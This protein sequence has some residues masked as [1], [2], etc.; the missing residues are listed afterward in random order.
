MVVSKCATG[1]KKNTECL[2]RTGGQ[3]LNPDILTTGKIQRHSVEKMSFLLAFKY[4]GQSNEAVS[5]TDVPA[6][7][8]SE[9]S[10]SM[11]L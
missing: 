6:S 8:E 2:L 7:S 1:K 5:V 4:F 10:T 11:N 9:L 3:D